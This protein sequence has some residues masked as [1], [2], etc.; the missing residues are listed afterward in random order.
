MNLSVKC[1]K[2]PEAWKKG[3]ISKLH[4]KDDLS[5]CGKW[6]AIYLLSVP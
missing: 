4:K 6:R 5:L 1:K 2:I 3:D